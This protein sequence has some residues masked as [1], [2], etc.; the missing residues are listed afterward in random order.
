LCKSWA[1][2]ISNVLFRLWTTFAFFL[3]SMQLSRFLLVSKDQQ[4]IMPCFVLFREK[5]Y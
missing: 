5:H 1:F 4:S 2:W 3:F